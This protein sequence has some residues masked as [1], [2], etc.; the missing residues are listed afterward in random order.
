M[1]SPKR[2]FAALILASLVSCAGPYTKPYSIV[3]PAA[4]QQPMPGK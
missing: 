2:I 4:T 1:K 3:Q